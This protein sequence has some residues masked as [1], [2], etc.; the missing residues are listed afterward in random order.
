MW[1]L[2]HGY[3]PDSITR[4]FTA[5]LQNELK[6][7]LPHPKN[8][9]AKSF[10]VY[11]YIKEWNCVPDSLKIITT[12]SNFTLKYKTHLVDSIWSDEKK[13]QASKPLVRIYG[14]QHIRLVFGRRY[15]YDAFG[16]R[17]EGKPK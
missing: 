2:A 16:T 17:K 11:S 5:N 9:K 7:V 10:F 15:R 13:T 6:F 14:K 3:I 1:K 8:D 12:L 4:Y